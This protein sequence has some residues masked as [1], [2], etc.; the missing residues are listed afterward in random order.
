M[1]RLAVQTGM[2]VLYEIENGNFKLNSPSDRLVEKSKRKA[3]KD[4]FS[5]Q[6][7]FRNMTDKDI[8][9]VQKWVDEDWDHHRKRL[10]QCV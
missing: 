7:R 8:E 10:E 4:Y 5:L 6:G 3:V 1:G 2:W 9:M